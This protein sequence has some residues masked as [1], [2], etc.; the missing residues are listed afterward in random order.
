MYLCIYIATHLQRVYL[1][2]LQAVLQSKSRCAWRWRSSELR[3]TLGGHKRDSLEKHWVRVLEWTQRCTW[4]LYW[5]EFGDALGGQDQAVLEMHV[6]GV[7]EW[8]WSCTWRP[9]SSNSEIHLGAVIEWVWRCTW[10]PRSSWTQR[11]TWRPWLSEFGDA[12]G[13]RDGGTQRCT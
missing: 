9:R 6:E 1:E 10:R 3:D 8:V 12:F 13:G 2:W 7:I 4:R 11:C 5:S